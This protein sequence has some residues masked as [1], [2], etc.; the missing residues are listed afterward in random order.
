V[1]SLCSSSTFTEGKLSAKARRIILAQLGQPGFFTSYVSRM[2]AGPEKPDAEVAMCEL[3]RSL[4]SAGIPSET[5]LK[6]IAA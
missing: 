2:F 1:L 6:A 5:G 4:E 3:I